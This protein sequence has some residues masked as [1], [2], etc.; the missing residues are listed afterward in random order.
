MAKFTDLPELEADFDSDG[1]VDGGDFL[2]WQRGE[3]PNPLSSSDLD[4]W[5]AN[6]GYVAGSITP[7]STTVPEPASIVLLLSAFACGLRR[8]RLTWTQ[9]KWETSVQ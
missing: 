7:A 9:P 6:F 5:Q 8:R 1:D 4:D 3:S 2:I